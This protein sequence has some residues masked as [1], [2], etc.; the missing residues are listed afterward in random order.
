MKKT[1]LFLPV[2]GITLLGA[3][4]AAVGLSGC[5][6]RMVYPG[7]A[8]DAVTADAAFNGFY[9]GAPYTAYTAADGTVLRGWLL[10]RGAGKPL[11][12]MYPGNGMSAGDFLPMATTDT[13]RSYLLLNYRGYGSSEGTPSEKNLVQ[14]ARYALKQAV[15]QTGAS[16]VALVGFS[17]GTGVAVQVAAQEPVQALVLICPFDSMENVACD[18]VPLL[19]R[20]FLS[21]TYDSAAYAPQVTCPVTVFRAEQDEIVGA[22]RT[23]SLIRSFGRPVTHHAIPATHNTILASP[24][25]T[26][27][28]RAELRKMLDV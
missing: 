17:L 2:L 13:E 8:K 22:A 26:E 25:F 15:Q 24:G 27:K 9:G 20:L 4:T 7:A 5:V 16:S 1:L 23:E 12:V 21:D 28:L 3:L 10:N 11:V 18:I 19:P 6:S 14:D